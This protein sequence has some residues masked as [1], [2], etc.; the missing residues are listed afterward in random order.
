MCGLAESSESLAACSMRTVT[1]LLP[2]TEICNK[3]A[4][5][6]IDDKSFA[7]NRISVG[8]VMP[9]TH[10]NNPAMALLPRLRSITSQR[11]LPVTLTQYVEE[12][13]SAS[14]ARTYIEAQIYVSAGDGRKRVSEAQP[15]ACNMKSPD[16]CQRHWHVLKSRRSDGAHRS[17][18]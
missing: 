4:A 18:I 11:C 5:K 14:C 15:E 16:L 2:S 7:L 9:V 10:R 1:E 12:A 13:A 8:V 3:R 6:Y 17:V